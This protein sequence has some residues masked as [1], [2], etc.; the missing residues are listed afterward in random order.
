M[1]KIKVAVIGTGALGSIHAKIYAESKNV[2]L[3]GICD[4][5]YDTSCSNDVLVI[6]VSA[7]LP[8]YFIERGF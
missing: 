7:N 8:S 5:L 4:C 6:T 2:E 3:V 1:P